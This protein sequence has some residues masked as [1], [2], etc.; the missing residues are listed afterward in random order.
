MRPP[1][2]PPDGPVLSLVGARHGRP[3][4]QLLQQGFHW[5]PVWG[6]LQTGRQ[7]ALYSGECGERTHRHAHTHTHSVQWQQ[8]RVCPLDVSN[9]GSHWIPFRSSSKVWSQIYSFH[10]SVFHILL[11]GEFYINIYCRN[12]QSSS[13][14]ILLIQKRRQRFWDSRVVVEKQ[15]GAAGMY[16]E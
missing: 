11:F 5:V 1:I 7:D 12:L 16:R 2:W 9:R 10:M 8:T 15:S 3:T 13:E 4:L 14:E 6:T